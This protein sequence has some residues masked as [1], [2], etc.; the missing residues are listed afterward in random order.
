MF[1]SII[2]PVYKV[3]P[4]L[5]ECLDSITASELDCWEAILIDDGSPDGCPQI[6]DEYAAK[7]KRFQVIHQQNAGVAAA[8]NV[9]LD[10]AQGEWVWFVDSDDVVD[11]RPVVDMVTWLQEHHDVDLVVFDLNTFKDN[12]SDNKEVRVKVNVSVSVERDVDVP[13]EKNIFLLENVI[14]HH[15]RLW[16]RRDI[17]EKYLIRYTMGVRLAEDLEFMYKCMTLCQHPVKID[18]TL[19]YYRV[20]EGSATQNSTYRAKAVEDLQIVI[21]SL[22]RWIQKYDIKP[23]PWLDLRIMKLM[24][25][26]LFSASAVN[27]N[28]NAKHKVNK[29]FQ[30]Q[31]RELIAGYRNLGFPFVKKLKYRLAEINVRV[32]FL[33]NRIYLG[34]KKLK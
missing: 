19:Y 23:E 5:R 8:R 21:G 30:K 14:F 25:N 18:T 10:M 31:T 1:L 22:A 26:L 4:Y 29:T 6:C 7:D 9:G 34:L 2:I 11:M 16:Y 13:V 28:D 24:Q 17:I 3:E 20:R 27:V 32:Y 33:V 15:Q 12:E